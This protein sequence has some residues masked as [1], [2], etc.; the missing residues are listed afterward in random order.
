[1]KNADVATFYIAKFA[2]F[3]IFIIAI[4]NKIVMSFKY[5]SSLTSIHFAQY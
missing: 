2:T 1:M 4:K 5:A 3:A